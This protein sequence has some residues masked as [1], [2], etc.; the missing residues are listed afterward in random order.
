MEEWTSWCYCVVYKWQLYSFFRWKIQ[1]SRTGSGRRSGLQE[2]LFCRETGRSWE[3][4]RSLEMGSTSPGHSQPFL[5]EKVWRICPVLRYELLA[6]G[7]AHAV[8]YGRCRFASHSRRRP[9]PVPTTGIWDLAMD[10][11]P[12]MAAGLSIH[13]ALSQLR[14][15]QDGFPDRHKGFI[16]A[17]AGCL[18]GRSRPL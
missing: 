14:S 1:P 17:L 15:S 8:L 11:I 6:A 16:S 13:R 12:G 3:V 10:A 4:G 9:A 2:S 5:R 7:Q 18:A